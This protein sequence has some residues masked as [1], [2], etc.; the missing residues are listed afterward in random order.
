MTLDVGSHPAERGTVRRHT[1]AELDRASRQVCAIEQEAGSAGF[2]PMG[3]GLWSLGGSWCRRHAL[4]EFLGDTKERHKIILDPEVLGDAP[5]LTHWLP[6]L[7]VVHQGLWTDVFSKR[8]PGVE[9]IDYRSRGV[10]HLYL[11]SCDQPDLHTD[12]QIISLPENYL[13]RVMDAAVLTSA[14]GG[15]IHGNPDACWIF[16]A[17]FVHLGCRPEAD[18]TVDRFTDRGEA[19]IGW[20]FDFR[21]DVVTAI[22][23]DQLLRLHRSLD[24]HPADAGIGDLGHR[25][26]NTVAHQLEEAKCSSGGHLRD[27][28]VQF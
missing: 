1:C 22:E 11:D 3:F 13:V 20:K 15:S 10:R 23:P 25:P 28:F 2:A 21:G 17:E 18:N 27:H 14:V 6:G 7:E 24:R 9:K 16:V 8:S 26:Y 4:P 19:Q 12:R 5:E